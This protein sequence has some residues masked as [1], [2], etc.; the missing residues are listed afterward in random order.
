MTNFYSRLLHIKKAYTL[1]VV[2]LQSLLI[3]LLL[4]SSSHAEVP[5]PQRLMEETS[6]AMIK[7]FIAQ[8]D[9]IRKDHQVAHQLINDHLVPKINFPLMSRWVLGKNWKKATPEQRKEFIKEFKGLVIKFYSRALLQYLEKNDLTEDIITFAAFRG[10]L[11]KKYA[12]VRAQVNPPKGGEPIKVNYD[13]YFGKAGTWQVYDV[14]VEGV[15]MVTTYRSSFKQ[16]IKQ[17]G[18]DALLSELRDK[19]SKLNQPEEKSQVAAS[20]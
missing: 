14:S 3:A 10:E 2:T 8:T 13:L 20:K 17:K 4:L 5:E 7:A 12:T 15:S 19:N 18:M 9:A 11:D 16:I 6:A 1:S